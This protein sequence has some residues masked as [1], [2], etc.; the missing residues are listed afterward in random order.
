M[1][2]TMTPNQ[3]IEHFGTQEAAAVALGLE[4]PS[5]AGWVKSGE[6]PEVR[7]YQIELATEGKLRASIPA[8]RV[9]KQKRKSA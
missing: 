4:Q 2:I 5:I 3:V 8:L 6:V 7:Q 9:K 1:S